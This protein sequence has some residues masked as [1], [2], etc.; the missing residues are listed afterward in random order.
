[1]PAG[2]KIRPLARQLD[3]SSAVVWVTTAH[4]ELL[5]LSAAAA[6]WLGV[7]GDSMF[8]RRCVPAA[9]SDDP[10]DRLAASLAP[11]PGLGE[12]GWLTHRVTPP[13]D[14]GQAVSPRQIGFA[15]IG[16]GA[17]VLIFAVG[18]DFASP[19]GTPDEPG[20][21]DE[22]ADAS[23]LRRQLDTW[24]KAEGV[25]ATVA[26]AG[27]S[28]AARRT[29]GRIRF[30]A[31][32]R[33]HVGFYGPTGCG[34]E[35]IA[36]RVHQLARGDEP[37]AVVDGPLMDAELLEATVGPLIAPL[38]ESQTAV[39][40]AL[41]LGLDETPVEAQQRLS[42][43]LA[44][45]GG[46]LR[47]LATAGSQ[48]GEL[49][50]PFDASGDVEAVPDVTDPADP[51]STRTG[52]RPD[53]V[54][55]LS[56]FSIRL[57]PLASRPEDIPLIAAATVDARHA[58]GEGL[59]ERLSRAALDALVVYPW[60]GEFVELDAA[61]RHAVRVARR[62]VIGA[63]DLPLAIRSYRPSDPAGASS[64]PTIPLDDA[65]RRFERRLIEEAI[66]A[67]GGNRAEAARRLGISRAK[68]IR[69][70][71]DEPND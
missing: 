49:R 62:G 34:G 43:L 31:S 28:A 32:V 13:G 30:A 11:P 69:R 2:S 54:D 18:G 68:L 24:R 23:E 35:T 58:S 33:C 70:L 37:L 42:E 57:E 36:S 14:H 10:L 53:L 61:I 21:A 71:A 8:R 12:V 63:E 41:V 15:R 5:Y 27:T 6:D 39:A 55:A 20:T 67:A 52:I 9:A 26:T 4:G 46:R 1:M 16:E 44:S 60:P 29:R 50:E 3:G 65:V 56:V 59:G 25:R 64:R 40:S 22:L 17:D 51:S 19:S 45:F 47:L 48:P 7:D 38:S 66:E